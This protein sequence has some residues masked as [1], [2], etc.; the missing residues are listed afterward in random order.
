MDDELKLT[1]ASMTPTTQEER[2][3]NEHI[4]GEVYLVDH[5]KIKTI[6]DV[7]LFIEVAY[8]TFPDSDPNFLKAKRILKKME[9]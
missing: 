4:K 2:E 1:G 8:F 6:E 7:Q 5:T 3:A 9:N